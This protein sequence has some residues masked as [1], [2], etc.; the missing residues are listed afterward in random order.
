MK[1]VECAYCGRELEVPDDV[2][3]V[4]CNKRCFELFTA[5]IINDS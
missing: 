2:E 4:V 1:K 3:T 5:T